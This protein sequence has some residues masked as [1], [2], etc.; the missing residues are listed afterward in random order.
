MKEAAENARELAKANA[1]MA[2][3]MAAQTK[4]EHENY[5]SLYEEYIKNKIS[6]DNSET[7]K[8]ALRQATDD[9]CEALG[10]EWDALDRLQ[11]KYED[12]NKEIAKK[13]V[14]QAE[15]DIKTT[16]DTITA[17]GRNM[18]I[19]NTGDT[20]EWEGAQGTNKSWEIGY[21]DDSIF[22]NRNEEKFVVENIT[23]A[24][25]GAGFKEYDDYMGLPTGDFR[26]DQYGMRLMSQDAENDYEIDIDTY[27]KAYETIRD[28]V[29]RMA[30]D[31]SLTQE[32]LSKSELYMG[33]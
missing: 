33:L 2:M 29:N 26:I 16:Q 32:Q 5:K 13:A 20:Y 12:V 23:K 18:L 31:K 3:E 14:A 17:V 10:A 11:G 9:L 7:S 6:L 1:E 28:E 21:Q 30:A 27:L 15:E 22:A 8:Q 25:L 19:K 4:E 24:M